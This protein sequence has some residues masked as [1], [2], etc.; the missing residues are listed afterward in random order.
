MIGALGLRPS[1]DLNPEFTGEKSC[2]TAFLGS[3]AFKLATVN[4]FLLAASRQ[5]VL[6]QADEAGH[7]LGLAVA[8]AEK[9]RELKSGNSTGLI[10][11]DK[12]TI[13]YRPVTP[14]WRRVNLDRVVP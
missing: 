10:S 1:P 6:S 13:R 7:L 8:T 5:D 11:G 9:L 14:A 3:Q 4:L 12:L 2:K